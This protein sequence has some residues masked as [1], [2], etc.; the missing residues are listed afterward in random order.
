[1]PKI[2]TLYETT[3]QLRHL[4]SYPR[5][6]PMDQSNWDYIVSGWHDDDGS[7]RLSLPLFAELWRR[8]ERKMNMMMSILIGKINDFRM[9]IIARANQPSGNLTAPSLE[10]KLAPT[11]THIE[12]EKLDGKWIA[13]DIIKSF[14]S[15]FL[16]GMWWAFDLWLHHVVKNGLSRGQNGRTDEII[17]LRRVE[18]FRIGDSGNVIWESHL[19]QWGPTLA[20]T[21]HSH[22]MFL[23]EG[24]GSTFSILSARLVL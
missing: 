10:P 11:S 21:W 12:Q 22:R 18:W 4:S 23:P 7:S 20:H 14:S 16:N 8:A 3:D 6:S 2:W 1:M 17:F 24:I 9:I 15:F 19:N 5:K 13:N